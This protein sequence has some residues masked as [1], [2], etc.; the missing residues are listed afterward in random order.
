[1]RQTVHINVH[2]VATEKKTKLFGPPTTFKLSR[3][4]APELALTLTTMLTTYL[5]G[6][7]L[8]DRQQSMRAGLK[9]NFVAANRACITP[10]PEM[11][12][13]GMFSP[14]PQ[15]A[16]TSLDMYSHTNAHGM[17]QTVPRGQS[18]AFS[19]PN[20]RHGLHKP[21]SRG[22]SMMS[23]T[24]RR[25]P[26]PQIA[27]EAS[28]PAFDLHT[29]STQ[30]RSTS[31][32][33]QGMSPHGLSASPVPFN[34]TPEPRRAKTPSQYHRATYAYEALSEWA[35]GDGTRVPIVPIG[36]GVRVAR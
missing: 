35:D 2:H 21:A 16:S 7:H 25:T 24:K 10:D 12:D 13:S 31:R 23:A 4:T 28:T 3:Q 32:L 1:M 19:G 6:M 26:V 30:Q 17:S 9:F 11:M 5:G 18:P 15:R 34:L 8:Q 36:A 20:P 33:S 22:A 27:F 14:Q 29:P